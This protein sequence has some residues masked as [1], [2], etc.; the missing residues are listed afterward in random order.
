MNREVAE[1]IKYV[2][3]SQGWVDIQQMM[4]DEIKEN[5]DELQHIM[6][7]RPDT[8]TGK[9]ALKYAI[10]ASAIEDLKEQILGSQKILQSDRTR[11]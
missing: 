5:R 11:S 7:K 2:L 8:L 6:A 10:R 1:R 4:D 3:Q 9:T